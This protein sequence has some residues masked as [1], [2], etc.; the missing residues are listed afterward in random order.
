M[1]N[2]S[3]FSRSRRELLRFAGAGF[4]HLALAGLLGQTARANEK[5]LAPKQP[6]FNPKA[7]RVI[8]LFME[9]AISGLDTFDYKP[10]LQKNG[11]KSG[12]GGGVLTP[13]RFQFR[14]YGQTGTW[15]SEL[16][17]NIAAHADELCWIRGLHTDTPAHPQAV[18]Q[19]H[20]GSAN[21]ALARPAWVHGY[22]MGS[23]LKTKTCPDTSPLILRQISEEPSITAVHFCRL[24]TRALA[25]A[26]PDSCQTSGPRCPRFCSGSKL[27]SCRR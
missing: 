13:S 27:T 4:G 12:P 11:G 1:T 22:S 2:A 25:S 14:Q 5:P 18:V 20:T 16:M 10:K 7:K 23:E 24:T 21:A 6:H 9:G 15:F 8:F 26:M 19:L 3:N 17:P